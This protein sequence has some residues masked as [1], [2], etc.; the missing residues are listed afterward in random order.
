MHYLAQ[1]KRKRTLDHYLPKSSA[2]KAELKTFNSCT[3]LTK[4]IS[5]SKLFKKFYH[6]KNANT[7]IAF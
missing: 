7:C 3:S 2:H 1:V 4:Q 6:G 5:D